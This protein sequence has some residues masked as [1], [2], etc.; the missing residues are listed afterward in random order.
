MRPVVAAVAMIALTPTMCGA[1]GGGLQALS[2][3]SGQRPAGRNGPSPRHALLGLGLRGGTSVG[4]EQVMRNLVS[5]VENLKKAAGVVPG[6]HLVIGYQVVGGR[7]EHSAVVRRFIA[8]HSAALTAA[9]QFPL[10]EV[11]S[12][13]TMMREALQDNEADVAISTPAPWGGLPWDGSTGHLQPPAAAAHH[14]AAPA[15]R[16][17]KVTVA[18]T[19]KCG[20]TEL[21]QSVGIVGGCAELGA[22]TAPTIMNSD[23]WPIW[24]VQVPMYTRHALVEYK[25][26]KVDTT[27]GEV[28]EWEPVGEEENRRL[29]LVNRYLTSA[30]MVIDDG[31]FGCIPAQE[32]DTVSHATQA[33]VRTSPPPTSAPQPHGIATIRP[34]VASHVGRVNQ[35]QFDAGGAVGGAKKF[36]SGSIA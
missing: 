10:Q 2:L 21:G 34:D 6:D 1:T 18:F 26:V 32:G 22:W 31:E 14:A 29:S 30:T 36:W 27:T 20:S 7:Q 4:Q 33:D 9:L 12:V 11:P 13:F 5:I 3:R 25:Y 23:A 28:A 15:V 24:K 19:V 8:D 17:P 16:I 35:R